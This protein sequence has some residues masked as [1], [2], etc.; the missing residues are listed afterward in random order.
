MIKIP[1]FDGKELF[2]YHRFDVGDRLIKVDLGEWKSP[3]STFITAHDNARGCKTL[4]Q[5]E[6]TAAI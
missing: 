1:N 5:I 3:S 2:P 6:A 4:A